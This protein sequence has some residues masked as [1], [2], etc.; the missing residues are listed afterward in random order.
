MAQC[1]GKSKSKQNVTIRK[2]VDPSKVINYT[3]A[4]KSNRR[5]SGR[6]VNMCEVC[7]TRTVSTICPI[8][9]T[10]IEPTKN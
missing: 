10:P 7:R 5:P 6:I 4:V 8:C 3:S 2:K 9:N 1:C